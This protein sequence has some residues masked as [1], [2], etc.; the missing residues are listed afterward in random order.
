MSETRLL[1]AKITA[2]RQ[3]GCIDDWAGSLSEGAPLQLYQNCHGG[4]NQAWVLL[5]SR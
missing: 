3:P 4:L 5:P 2:L 1:L